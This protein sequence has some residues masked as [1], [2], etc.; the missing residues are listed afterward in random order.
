VCF[1]ARSPTCSLIHTPK[2]KD[3]QR[4]IILGRFGFCCSLGF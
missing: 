3:K 1:S 2:N 4:E